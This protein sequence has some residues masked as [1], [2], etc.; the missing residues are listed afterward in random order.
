MVN[1]MYSIQK[2]HALNYRLPWS[3]EM[4]HASAQEAYERCF[5]GKWSP[6]GRGLWMMGSRDLST[7]QGFSLPCQ[8]C[9]V[10]LH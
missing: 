5:A 2:N 1:G 6:P 9:A 4:A 10:H 8:N 7:G 3:E